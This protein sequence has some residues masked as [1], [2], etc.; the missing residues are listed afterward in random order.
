MAKRKIIT[1][2]SKKFL[3]NISNAF[4]TKSKKKK[5][6]LI[7]NYFKQTKE[8]TTNLITKTFTPS[9]TKKIDNLN[10]GSIMGLISKAQTDIIRKKLDYAEI[11]KLAPEIEQAALLVIISIIS[12]N[13]IEYSTL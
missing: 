11:I 9:T 10:L 7:K 13:S 5:T 6:K 12:Y 2:K 3:T 8:E 4:T 1:S